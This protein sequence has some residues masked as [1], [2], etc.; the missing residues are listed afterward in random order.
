MAKPSIEASE[1]GLTE[2]VERS[3]MSDTPACPMDSALVL[4]CLPKKNS[5]A[6]PIYC[7]NEKNG[8]DNKVKI[9][10]VLMYTCFGAFLE[11]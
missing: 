11:K 1:A 4:G 8:N 7:P 6:S 5:L 10:R 2:T 3:P 9:R